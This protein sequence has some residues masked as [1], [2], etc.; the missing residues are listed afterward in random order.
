MFA[1]NSILYVDAL[2]LSRLL[3]SFSVQRMSVTS[4]LFGISNVVKVSYSQIFPIESI[5]S[6]VQDT[7]DLLQEY[8]A[9]PS[10]LI[11][12]LF[13]IGVLALGILIGFV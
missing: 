2:L 12:T 4:S 10:W 1:P 3:I 7:H 8:Y 13:V 9:W 6:F 11:Y 5:S